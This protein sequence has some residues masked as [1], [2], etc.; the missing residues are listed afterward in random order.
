[1]HKDRQTFFFTKVFETL[2]WTFLNYLEMQIFGLILVE[3]MYSNEEGSAAFTSPR[4]TLSS[5]N[6][7][8]ATNSESSL[9]KLWV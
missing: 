4:M 6:D 5:L 2:L 9:P 7:T 8:N 1:M 3:I